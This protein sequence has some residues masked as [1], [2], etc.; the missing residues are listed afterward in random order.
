ML[1]KNDYNIIWAAVHNVVDGYPIF[2]AEAKK[3][4]NIP[5][6]Y[7]D[8]MSEKLINQS[9]LSLIEKQFIAACLYL[10][11]LFMD[12]NDAGAVM[13]C[14][15]A[16]LHETYKKILHEWNINEVD[17]KPMFDKLKEEVQK[18]IN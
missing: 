13:D 3:I 11:I 8:Y 4:L 12:E 17:Y 5:E 10:C 16:D 7:W 2:P 15:L 9:N 14:N 1:E 6:D 18:K